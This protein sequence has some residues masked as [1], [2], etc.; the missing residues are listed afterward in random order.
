MEPI[1][2]ERCIGGRDLT[3]PRLAPD[4]SILVYALSTAGETRLIVHHFDGSPQQELASRPALRPGRGMGGGAWTF[5]ADATSVVYVAVDGNLWQQPLV[6][7]AAAALT[8]HGP[9]RSASGPCVS[10]DGR[11]VVY[12]LDLAEVHVVSLVT[13]HTRRLDDGTAD[14]CMDPFVDGAGTVRWMAWNVPDMAWD[15]SRVAYSNLA[16]GARQRNDVAPTRSCVQQPRVLPSGE[17]IWVRDDHDWLNVWIG[18]APLVDE[19]FEHAG[20]SWGP[21]QRS[22]DWSPDGRFVA[23]ARNEAGFGRLCIIEIATV[24]VTQVA[25]GVHGQLSWQG[26]RLSA[27]RSGARTPTQVVVYDTETWGRAEVA[28]ATTSAWSSDELIEPE[29]VELP[30][31]DGVVHA[32]LYRNAG[33]DGRLIVWLHGGPTDQWM[34]T[35]MPRISYWWSRGWSILVPDH[36]GSTGHGRAYQQALRGRW[37]ELDVSDTLAAAHFAVS[38]RWATRHRM[39][40]FGSSAGGFTALG[41]MAAEPH[42]FAAGVVLYPVSDLLEL[43]ERSHRFERHYTDSL[44]GPLPESAA[45]YRERSPA[46]HVDRSVGTPIL[47]MHG[48]LDAVV[49]VGQSRVFAQRVRTAGGVAELQV[50]PDEGHGFRQPANQLD[51][52]RRAGDFLSRH[53]PVA[54]RS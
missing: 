28:R 14:F 46:Y 24:K 40:V 50:Y 9:D 36:R 26:P 15:A 32:R 31:S 2:A 52:Y 8:D 21:G 53:V 30:V 35:F 22:Y 6:G 17:P 5:S 16:S 18:D 1:A 12:V 54:S 29:L 39:V 20:P 27:L 48:E 43:A 45:L 3:E 25:R 33:S 13:G 10:S 41:A 51:E 47:I 34:V 11:N 7:G 19:P 44:V 4:G 23:V 38:A 37:G 42:C 49:P